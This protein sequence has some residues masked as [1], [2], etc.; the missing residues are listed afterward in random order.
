MKKRLYLWAATAITIGLIVT[1]CT[2]GAKKKHYT[3]SAERAYKAGQY[4][5][6]RIEYMNLL[7]MDP[8]S[9]HA[10][11]QLGSI[12]AEDGVPLRAGMFLKKAL[13]LDPSDK[14]TRRRLARVY[15]AV[16]R[17]AD[18]R[19]EALVLLHETPADGEALIILVDASQK[20]EEIAD[21]EQQMAKFPQPQSAYFQ[22][23][24]AG[25][26]AK[27]SDRA[28]IEP[29]LQKAVAAGRDLGVT[30]VALGSWYRAKR[31]FK[32]AAAEFERAAN[33]APIRST[34]RMPYAEFKVQMGAL[35]E[36]TAFL[37]NITGRAPDFL[38]AWSLLG[39][40]ANREKKYDDALKLIE[41][42]LT[43]DPGNIEARVVQA[44]SWLAKNET[45]KALESL[46]NL[47]HTYPQTPMIK[48]SLARTYLQS[49]NTKQA[50][51]EL[52]EVV[53]L[54]PGFVEA[55]LLH[56]ELRL[57][58]GDAQSVVQELQKMAAAA[59][60]LAPAKLL[61]AEAYRMLGRLDEAATVVEEESKHYPQNASYQAMLGM[62]FRQQSKLQASRK[63]FEKAVELEPANIAALDQLVELDIMDKAYA[64][65][66]RRIEQL[67]QKQPGAADAYYFEGKVDAAE[68]KFDLA[69]AA[70]FKA[71][72]L[73]PNQTRAY[74]LLIPIYARANKLPEALARINA[75]VARKP[76]DVRPLLLSGL[77]YDQLKDA[78]KARDVYE[79]VLTLTPNSIPA[80]NNL[81]YIYAEKLNDLNRARE[82]AQKARSL[83]PSDASVLD[84]L[85]WIAYRQGDYQLAADLL[86]QSAAKSPGNSEI[87]YH[88][89]MAS[90]MMG[91]SDAARV[92]LEKA[93]AAAEEFA[94]KDEA[95]R[96]LAMLDDKKGE[97][98]PAAE[99]EALLKQQPNDPLALLRL[100]EVYEREGAPAKAAEVYERAFGA[101]PKLAAAAMKLARLNAGPLKNPDKALQFAK[102]AR[103]L[104]PADP[105]A[106]ATV[107]A[108]ALQL[109]NTAWAYSLLQESAHE[110]PNDPAVLHDLAWAAYDLGKIPEAQ[111]SMQ[112]SLDADPNGA[113]SKDARVFLSITKPA[114]NQKDLHASENEVEKVLAADSDY[115]PALMARAQIQTAKGDLKAAAA[116]YSQILQS[117]PDF[118]PAQRD[119]SAL[120]IEDPQNAGAAYDLA[121]R[122]RKNLPED[123]KVAI[124]LA[125]ASYERK[126][127]ARAVQLLEQAGRQQTLDAVSLYYLGMSHVQARQTAE[128]RQALNEALK[129]GLGEPQAENA[130]RALAALDGK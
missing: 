47:D 128:A 101:N 106:T 100:G 17:T 115:L 53:R 87:Q 120:L 123:A 57:R 39:K 71:I 66:H 4:D 81:A 23:A 22:L 104:S 55:V 27:K 25:I 65:A 92:A 114:L 93:S 70:L 31:D 28:A 82:L 43:R 129:K 44:E 95:R 99:L 111:N 98:I 16:G 32:Q 15:L 119:L 124:V 125:R 60:E 41:N 91:R 102:K 6:A 94:G 90:Y 54:S 38:P 11:A 108:I 48:Y 74:D 89:G 37:R 121:S 21:T 40:I 10:Y 109:K 118:A 116:T 127:F 9:A 7:R 59:P 69:Q 83:A 56:G 77:I 130:K 97:N 13:E 112:R 3:E 8:G 75:I 12:W 1:G 63:A 26:A 86:G 122:A 68:G 78:G 50:M 30:H 80:L 52:D 58:S 5:K 36:A 49:G 110:L 45:K 64:E 84:T 14:V 42:A 85:G 79:K 117:S 33:A 72:E 67:R 29:A 62:I 113:A 2:A 24:T 103:E 73:D 61:L 88:F 20:P 76:N 35:E 18:A 107:G 96:R 126:E 51:A 105:K 46:D 19:K 34:E